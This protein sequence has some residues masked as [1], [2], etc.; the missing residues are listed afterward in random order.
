[1][2]QCDKALRLVVVDPDESFRAE[3]KSLSHVGID[4]VFAE[5]E[6]IAE[7]AVT[8]TSRDVIVVC[9]QTP[10]RLALIA[11]ICAKP[12]A[13]PVIAIG[14]AGFEHKPLE[15]VLVLAELR[16]ACASAPKPIDGPELVLLATHCQSP[17]PKR[18]GR[19][20]ASAAP[21]KRDQL[22]G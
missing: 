6:A 22:Q 8:M 1:M 17:R 7:A 11:T 9:V 13:P 18:E 10:A 16:G 14:G 12:G 5:P 19:A 3:L 21:H 15:H 2:G 20:M 4:V